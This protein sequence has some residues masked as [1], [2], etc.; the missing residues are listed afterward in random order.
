MFF[1]KSKSYHEE[2]AANLYGALVLGGGPSSEAENHVDADALEIPLDKL[3]RFNAKRLIMLEAFLFVATS[4]ATMPMEKETTPLLIPV[5]PLAVQLSKHIQEKWAERGISTVDH[6]K[7]AERCFAEVTGALEAPFKWGRMRLDEFYVDPDK[8]GEHYISW[9]DQ[10]LKEF[11][12]M[13]RVVEE[14]T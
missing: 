10:C 14:G 5:H 1:G 9:T 8:S 12:A 2:F 6:H 13:K 3:E 11:R 4:I 7:V